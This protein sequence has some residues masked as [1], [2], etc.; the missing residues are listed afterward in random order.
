MYSFLNKNISF[1]LHFYFDFSIINFSIESKK[2]QASIALLFYLTTSL[3]D[4]T[5]TFYCLTVIIS[6][7]HL[8]PGKTITGMVKS[9]NQKIYNLI[10]T[11]S[12]ADLRLSLLCI[13]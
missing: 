7:I 9:K 2:L 12:E 5:N 4:S 13:S 11:T 3:E 6:S 8:T 10:E 1:G